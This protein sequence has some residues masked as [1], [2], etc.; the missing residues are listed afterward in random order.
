M[1]GP[2]LLILLVVAHDGV[3]LTLV[4]IG[5]PGAVAP[6]LITDAII[7][8]LS[9]SANFLV[10]KQAAGRQRQQKQEKDDRAHISP[11]VT[12]SFTPVSTQ[13]CGF[14]CLTR[15]VHE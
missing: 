5:S 13:R 8:R 4:G 2:V 6:V 9:Q 7:G 15:G 11:R 1:I 10:G 12:R 3:V 14:S